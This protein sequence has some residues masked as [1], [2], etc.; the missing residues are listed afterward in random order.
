MLNVLFVLLLQKMIS[1]TSALG[2]NFYKGQKAV[3]E[4]TNAGQE[5]V[6]NASLTYLKEKAKLKANNFHN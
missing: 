5:S 4:L 1:S 2:S 3:T 6:I